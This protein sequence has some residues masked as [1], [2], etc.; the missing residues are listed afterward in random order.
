[1]PTWTIRIKDDEDNTEMISL[2]AATATE[3]VRLAE[4]D[5]DRVVSI[6]RLYGT[7]GRKFERFDMT[8]MAFSIIAGAFYFIGVFV[9]GSGFRFMS[10]S[11]MSSTGQTVSYVLMAVFG[12][13]V[14]ATV[15]AGLLR[16]V[17][18][19]NFAKRQRSVEAAGE[20][21]RTMIKHDSLARLVQHPVMRLIELVTAIGI[22]VFVISQVGTEEPVGPFW[23]LLPL[24]VLTVT[25][26]PPLGERNI[27]GG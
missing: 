13:G 24:I 15:A 23:F 8:I 11:E 7:G 21:H 25:A 12:V 18:R 1:M 19:K 9:R 10:L 5:M 16:L 27:W 6:E 2:Y 17:Y 26:Q 22:G 3:A 20:V 4:V 14:F